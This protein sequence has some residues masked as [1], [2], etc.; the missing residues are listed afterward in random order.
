MDDSFDTA[1]SYHVI[2]NLK[3][4]LS[5]LCKGSNKVKCVNFHFHFPEN[6]FP[7]KLLFSGQGSSLAVKRTGEKGMTSLTGKV[8]QIGNQ[9]FVKSALGHLEKVFFKK[10]DML[11]F[12]Y[13]P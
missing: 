2:F 12:D 10:G 1:F 4:D 6:F 3:H 13:L 9:D 5:S 11:C 7:L 8:L